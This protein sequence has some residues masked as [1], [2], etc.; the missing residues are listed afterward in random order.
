MTVLS[1]CLGTIDRWDGVLS[2]AAQLGYNSIHF[3]PI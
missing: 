3:T 1:R 2:N